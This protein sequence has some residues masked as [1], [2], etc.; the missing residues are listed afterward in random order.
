[1][2]VYSGTGAGVL[3]SGRVNQV[4]GFAF[5]AVFVL[6]GL[7]GF[8]VSGGHHAVGADGGDLAG[9]FRVNVLHNSVHLIVGAVMIAAAIMGNRAA[10]NANA[11]FGAIYFVLFLAGLFAIGTAA[12]LI[13]LNLADNLLH[14]GLG[15]ALLGV[16]LIGDRGRV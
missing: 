4:V 6:V 5:G 7:S 16:A 9:L 11:T 10:R 15:L 12:N 13:A 3:S 8:V 2:T 1:M 14:L